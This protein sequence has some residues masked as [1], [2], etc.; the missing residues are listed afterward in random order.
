MTGIV[1]SIERYAIED[2]PGI[3]T[4]IFLKG[5]FLHCEWCS[6]PESQFITPEILYFSNKCIS[7]GR[8]I[9]YCPQDAI[10]LD[11]EF[12][13]VIDLDRCTLCGLCTE[14]CYSNAREI[15]GEEM[16]VEQVMNVVLRDKSFYE[17]S[18]G[19]L[20]ISGGEPLM[21]AA[22]VQEIVEECNKQGI[23]TAI[24]TTLYA[25]EKMV[26]STVENVDL[27][28]VDI[29]HLDP[30]K[31]L[32]H[33]GV[34][35]EKVL[36]NIQLVDDLGKK[37]IIRVPYIP[38]FN[39]DSESQR[40]IYLWAS[41]LKNLQ[42]IE[43]LPYHRL[44]MGKYQALGRKYPMGDIKPLKKQDLAFLVEIGAACGVQVKIGAQ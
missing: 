34:R 39:D 5:C 16:T 31:H 1:F 44:G 18:N 28:Y 29:K 9:R 26:A 36:K 25:D 6:N 30:T 22:F 38:G 32:T 35:N 3:R 41:H 37:M 13:L 7:C 40:Q 23:H 33:T 20:T 17:K 11:D 12:G 15:S 8:C 43:V 19:G 10:R 24:E 21:Q 14:V 42:W 27:V 2:G 4:V